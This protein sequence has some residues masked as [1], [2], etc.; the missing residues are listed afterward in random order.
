M[1][2]DALREGL[3]PRGLIALLMTISILQGLAR[4]AMRRTLIGTSR[5]VE[6][7]LRASLFDRLLTLSPR[8]YSRHSTGDLMSRATQDLE[9]VRM[10]VGPALMYSLDTL[11]LASYAL[12]MMLFISH[13]LTLI[14]FGLLPFVSLVVYA[15]SKRIHA[16]TLEAQEMKGKISGLVQESIAGM[17]LIQT[18]G[19]EAYQQSIMHDALL[20]NRRLQ[21]R[22]IRLQ[23]TFRPVLGLLFSFGQALILWRAGIL[24]NAAALS[25]GDYV[26]FAAYLTMLAWPMVAIGWSMNLV[27]RGDAGMKRLD[28]ILSSEDVL[29]SGSI[30]KTESRSLRFDRVSFSVKGHK[31]AILS[32][33]SFEVP[34]GST[35]GIVGPTGSGKS[36]LL[37]LAARLMEPSSGRIFLGDHELKDYKIATLRSLVALVPQDAFLFSDSLFENLRFGSPEASQEEVE[38]AAK[39]AHLLKDLPQFPQ[40]WD[41]LIGERGVTLSGGQRQRAT[42]A[43]ALLKNAP[44]LILDDCLSA[45]DRQT[46]EAMVAGLRLAMQGRS[47][48]IVSHR[49]SVMRH[50]DQVLV[51]DKGRVVERGFHTKL[52]SEDG[53]YRKLYRL[54]ELEGEL[55]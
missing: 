32:E 4:F 20:E 23:S 17:K 30:A 31:H 39:L 37:N 42:I 50:V 29:A 27:Q 12:V 25:L 40:S 2:I 44:L 53:L 45:V 6:R 24:I 8:F 11:F 3:V 15:L 52:L 55:S 7:D 47:T 28:T 21:M 43:R 54:Q 26:A 18:F 33:I 19:R 34:E 22:L 10:A 9:Q 1:A 49:M 13:T 46:E 48:L 14:V 51:L 41:T 35:L 5:R 36:T 16:A 38:L